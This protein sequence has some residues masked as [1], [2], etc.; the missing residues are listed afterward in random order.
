MIRVDLNSP[1]YCFLCFLTDFI[2][3]F[4]AAIFSGQ[5][6]LAFGLIMYSMQI[7]YESLC[8]GKK[9]HQSNLGI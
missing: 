2:V 7:G 8:C 6:L 9:T 5:I 1:H 3:L 4:K